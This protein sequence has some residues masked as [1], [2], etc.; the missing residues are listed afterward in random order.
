[1]AR[2]TQSRAK[3]LFDYNPETGDITWKAS[4]SNVVKIGQKA[5]SLDRLGNRIVIMA[6]KTIYRAHQIAFL[7][8][9]GYIPEEVD[10]IN[11][12]SSDNA[13]DNLRGVSHSENMQNR[14]L[15]SNNTTGIMGVAWNKNN[16]NWRVRIKHANIF[17]EVGSFINFL[18]ACCARKSAENRYGFHANHGRVQS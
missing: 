1:M 7:I 2:L 4:N 14:K 12:D 11:G 15:C 8:M 9:Q 18:D 5:G 16:N 13:W 3:E 17:H 10:H 6:D